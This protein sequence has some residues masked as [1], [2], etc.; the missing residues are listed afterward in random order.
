MWRMKTSLFWRVSVL[1]VFTAL[2]IP[3]YSQDQLSDHDHEQLKTFI[4]F[5][6]KSDNPSV[7]SSHLDW[8]SATLESLSPSPI[9]SVSS[10]H[11]ESPSREI[12]YSYDHVAHGFAARLTPSQASHLESL[13]GILSVI[14]DSFVEPHTTH[15]PQFLGLNDGYGLLP[16]SSYGE[17]VIIGVFDGGIWPEHQSFNDFGLTPVPKRWK[18]TCQTGPDFP[19][20][21]RKLIGAQAFYK[22]IEAHLGHR[23]DAD[24]SKDSRSPRDTSGHG[25]HCAATAAGSPVMNAGFHNYSVGEAKGVATKARIAAYKVM[26]KGGG[27][28]SDSLAG[29][30]QAVKDGVDVMSISLGDGYGTPYHRSPIAI[31]TFG[32]M[33]KGIVVSLAAGNNGAKGPKIVGNSAPWMLTVGG[34]TIDRESRADVILGDGQIIPGVSLYYGYPI[35][36]NT[37]YLEI[38]YI[39]KSDGSSNKCLPGSLSATQVAG[40]I[41]VCNA[42]LKNPAV[43]KASVVREARGVGMIHVQTIDQFEALGARNYPIPATEVT[44]SFGLRIITYITSNRKYDNKPTA[45]IMFRGTVTGSFSLSPAPKVATFSS[46]GPNPL[47][48]EILKPDVIAPGVNILAAR[49]GSDAEFVMMSG[50]SMACPHVSG[51]AA[52]LRNAFPKWSPAAIKSALMTT[53]Y[54]VYSSGKYITVINKTAGVNGK[55]STPFQHGSVHV[56][57]NKALNPGLVYDITPSDYEAFLCTIGH[58]KRQIKHFVKDREVDCDFVRLSTVGDL[59]YPSFSVVFESAEKSQTM[60]YKRVVTNVGISADAIYKLKIRSQTPYVKISVSPTNSCSVRV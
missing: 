58:N 4:V 57:P 1:L 26:W 60:K 11:Y 8:Y 7:F 41:V 38:V 17:D 10:D 19:S 34:S 20:C 56:D 33:E 18:G 27:V 43:K 35:P 13:P 14:P 51:L 46:T 30:E 16:N 42:D 3:S 25:T 9:S 37:T 2:I 39:Q 31:G 5:V 29:Y 12:M 21:N 54:T 32:S 55:I 36:Y 53:A 40:K 6:S 45:K 49:S 15:S 52:L 28:T 47:I 23:F 59:N 48:P 24:G 50:T 44:K 22:G